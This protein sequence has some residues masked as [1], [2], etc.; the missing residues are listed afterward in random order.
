MSKL[1]L[2]EGDSLEYLE[3]CP[4]VKAIFMD[5]PDNLGIP[6]DGPQLVSC[7]IDKLPEQ[8]YY[9]WIERLVMRAL[10]KAEVIWLSY[11]HSHDLEIK[12]L[13]RQILRTRHPSWGWREFL[14]THTFSQYNDNDCA[15]GYRPILRLL[16][17]GAKLYPDAIRVESE[18]MALGDPRAAGPRV[19]SNL[20]EFPRVVGNARE[21][22]PWHPCQHPNMLVKRMVDFSCAGDEVWLDCFLG[23]G[24]SFRACSVTGT[25][26]I[27]VELS[28]VYCE[29]I[30]GEF[31]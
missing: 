12:H 7:G 22:R 14:W 6:Y 17:P 10:L 18:R 2:I 30:R 23:S 29:K 5:P 11:H 25:P 20:W 3:G 24:T 28:S 19:P 1:T 15:V 4:S 13:I 27:G 26:C 16:R 21:R 9:G 31:P 8:Q